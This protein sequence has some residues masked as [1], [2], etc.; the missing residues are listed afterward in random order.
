MAA[1][2]AVLVEGARVKGRVTGVERYGVFV[3][4][5]G[6]QGR[7]GRGLVPTPETG[8]P[9]GS[10]LK[11]HFSVGQ[12][13]EAKILSVDAEGKIR[14]SIAALG[15]DDERGLFEAFKTAQTSQGSQG[16]GAGAAADAP[17]EGPAG[18]PER[19]RAPG[20][21]TLA[22]LLPRVAAAPKPAQAP[23]GAKAGAAATGPKSA[24]PAAPARQRRRRPRET[25]LPRRT[26][27]V[28][29]ER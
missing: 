3:Q 6:T 9:R 1:A 11:K 18:A 16:G 23:R 10:D 24:K 14:L 20:F 21:G 8:T 22:D 25:A 2:G 17:A 15:A 12:D 29:G 26:G 4:I 19:S 7:S 13:V 27:T 28:R 5:A